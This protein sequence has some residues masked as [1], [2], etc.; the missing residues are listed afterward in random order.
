VPAAVFVSGAPLLI[1]M[2]LAPEDP[3]L[4]AVSAWVADAV[5]DPAKPR[6]VGRVAVHEPAE[7]DVLPDC[8]ELP[9]TDQLTVAES[10]VSVPQAPPIDAT[11][12]LLVVNG[13]VAGDPFSCVSVTSGAVL[14]RVMLRGAAL[15]VLPA[16]SPCD[17]STV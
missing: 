11:A 5:N 2:D 9:V 12:T 15:P 7:H 3:V 14:S 1:V 17:A 10:P 4:P 6:G 16:P 13:K 8:V